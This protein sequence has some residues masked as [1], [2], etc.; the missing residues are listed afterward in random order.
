MV[1]SDIK[2][3]FSVLLTFALVVVSTGSAEL[4]NSTPS[5]DLS[6]TDSAGVS[7]QSAAVN[8]KE[9]SSLAVV[10]KDTILPDFEEKLSEKTDTSGTYFVGEIVVKFKDGSSKKDQL[11]LIRKNGLKIKRKT[12]SG[13]L[14]LRVDT[15]DEQRM[16]DVF[17]ADPNVE[18]T[19]LSYAAKSQLWG[20]G[21]GSSGSLSGCSNPNDP[22]FCMDNLR[23]IQLGAIDG[24]ALNRGSS[25]ITIAIIDTG[26]NYNHVDLQ[27]K[28][29]KNPGESGGGKETNGVDDDNN[30]KVDDWRGWNFTGDGQ[31]PNNNP[32]DDSGHGTLVAGAAAAST[33]NGLGIAGVNWYAKIMPLRVSYANGSIQTNFAA[34]AIKYA[35]DN[36]AK[37]INISSNLDVEPLVTYKNNIKYAQDRGV[38]V[39]ASSAYYN[40][41]QNCFIG[42]PA[43]YT[44]VIAVSGMGTDVTNVAG[45]ANTNSQY[46]PI[47]VSAAS[48]NTWTTT[49]D[50]GY[51]VYV[52]PTTSLAAPAVSGIAA[53]LLGCYANY[54]IVRESFKYGVLDYGVAGYDSKY[55]WGA[56]HLY[57][58]L[59]WACN[60]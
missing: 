51:T 57:W 10:E 43:G 50:G 48:G 36:G 20:F 19:G 47:R 7:T 27:N 52:F 35:V 37:V 58:Q 2:K 54:Y 38:L 60:L 9:N 12:D 59:K 39:V 55:G 53:A 13:P 8:V 30:G 33:N 4:L 32:M 24:W 25:S 3:H 11:A 34:D 21:G 26:V 49:K 40:Y 17:K 6:A 1:L 31:F 23:F 5:A 41:D 18:Y 28:I 15:G 44:D 16:I 46:S 22:Y 56:A 29:W 14:I 45:C 42:Y